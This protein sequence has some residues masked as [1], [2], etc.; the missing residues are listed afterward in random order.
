MDKQGFKQYV[1]I[2]A[3]FQRVQLAG[4][5]YH[6]YLC[7]LLTGLMAF[8]MFFSPA[9]AFGT[10][11]ARLS[12]QYTTHQ[13]GPGYLLAPVHDW[14]TAVL[15]QN[16]GLNEATYQKII[17]AMAGQDIPTSQ[18]FLTAE[19]HF[20]DNKILE[21]IVLV[22]QRKAKID[23]LL[24]FVAM[25]AVKRN[26]FYTLFGQV[27]HA[28]QDFYSHSNYIELS[29][30][31]NPSITQLT[32]ILPM[33]WTKRPE[34]LKT[35]YFYW[36]S[37]TDWEK[38]SHIDTCI[39]GLKSKPEFKNVPFRH[40]ND[41]CSFMNCSTIT[42]LDPKEYKS[43]EDAIANATSD[44]AELHYYLNKDDWST[45]MGSQAHLS[46]QKTLYEFARSLAERETGR[47]WLEIESKVRRIFGPQA[48]D[49]LVSLKTDTTKLISVSD[50]TAVKSMWKISSSKLKPG[51]SFQVL[52]PIL[53][54]SS[55]ALILVPSRTAHNN[56]TA[57]TSNALKLANYGVG[58]SSHALQAPTQTG[59]FEVRVYRYASQEEAALPFTVSSSL[60]TTSHETP[61]QNN[62]E[63]ISWKL[64][65]TN[66]NPNMPYTLKYTPYQA[67]LNPAQTYPVAL[68]G[69]GAPGGNYYQMEPFAAQR[70]PHLIFRQG[71][72]VNLISPLIAGDYQVRVYDPITKQQ[73][74]ALPL[75]VNEVT[76]NR[77]VPN[78][79]ANGNANPLSPS[80]ETTPTQENQVSSTISNPPNLPP[81]DCGI[82]GSE[83]AIMG[84][85]FAGYWRTTN[86]LMRLIQVSPGIFE[87]PSSASSYFKGSGNG[88]T[89]SGIFAD[90]T[91]DFHPGHFS[92]KMSQAGRCLSGTFQYDG[93]K[94][95]NEVVGY[96]DSK[97]SVPY[98]EIYELTERTEHLKQLVGGTVPFDQ[99]DNP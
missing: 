53:S 93:D 75:H 36:A 56:W 70:I 30:R 34:G 32:D 94:E 41:Y 5:A 88:D 91:G 45:P 80:V 99:L 85:G 12:S 92:F 26:E 62:R 67:G 66:L 68:V 52:G 63:T 76:S 2:H 38:F 98:G 6:F 20:D 90:D 28:M 14:I 21:S 33:D 74:S 89:F 9:K 10:W 59:E 43:F 97:P 1:F 87:G 19:N 24:P 18:A 22:E 83:N 65:P 71:T 35:G 40:P 79:N 44:K 4:C 49:V 16:H 23:T 13:E 48:E 37:I 54:S 31:K 57:A 64:N 50:S 86:G 39:Q 78:T 27:L 84:N 95:I 61:F 55:R 25:D 29:I 17:W 60:A 72:S 69:T 82:S 8:S 3:M 58:E 51:Q 15:K 11:N 96:R 42:N 46:S 73:I 81:A 7:C 47:Q 77:A